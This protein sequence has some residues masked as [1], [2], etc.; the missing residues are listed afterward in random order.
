[1][2]PG[3]LTPLFTDSLGHVF[4]IFAACLFTAGVFLMRELS[5]VEV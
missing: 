4:L 2:A 5:K 1:M 3:Y